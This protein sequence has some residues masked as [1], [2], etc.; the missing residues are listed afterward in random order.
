ML[1]G[2]T[3]RPIVFHVVC[4]RDFELRVEF[5]PFDCLIGVVRR[6][7]EDERLASLKRRVFVEDPEPPAR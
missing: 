5:D 1:D 3:V 2:R 6:C 7:D 4:G